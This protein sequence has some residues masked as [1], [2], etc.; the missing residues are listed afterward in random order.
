MY[1]CTVQFPAQG[2]KKKHSLRS[3]PKLL[4]YQRKVDFSRDESTLCT[5][6]AIFD[7]QKGRTE[8]LLARLNLENKKPLPLSLCPFSKA[9]SFDPFEQLPSFS[10]STLNKNPSIDADLSTPELSATSTTEALTSSCS[11]S[12]SSNWGFSAKPPSTSATSAVGT[13]STTAARQRGQETWLRSHVSTHCTWNTWLHMG[14]NRTISPS[15][16]SPKQTAHPAS[17]RS[18]PA[19]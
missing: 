1:H 17:V 2:R 14:S 15:R 9:S 3:K 12:A 10:A 11:S 13:A 7:H 8:L 4:H 6:A 18:P 16:S 5:N 19:R